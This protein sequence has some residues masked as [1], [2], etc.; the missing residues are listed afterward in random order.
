M[1]DNTC[2]T[3]QSVIDG[4]LRATNTLLAGRV[5]VV[6]GYGACGRGIAGAA[7]GLG[8]QVVVTEVD[9]V[10]ALEAVLAGFRVLPMADAAPAG[11]VFITAT[12]S[13]DVIA[14]GHLPDL[15]DGAIL[16]NAGHFDVEIDVRALAEAAVKVTRDVRPHTDEYLLADGRRLLLLAEGRV[17]NLVAAEGNPPQV[18]DVS[19]AGQALVLA[20]LATAAAGLPAGVHAVPAEIDEQIARLTLESSGARIDVLTPA[21]H[22]YLSSWRPGA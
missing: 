6:A 9:P 7:R 12:G 21:Q 15:R 20:W 4:V 3:G 5:V 14:A 11:E 10:R 1:F 17:V 19:F 18:M 13:R 16:A 8:A 22:E 2:G